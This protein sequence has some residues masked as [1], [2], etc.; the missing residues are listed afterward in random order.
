MSFCSTRLMFVMAVGSVALLA[1]SAAKANLGPVLTAGVFTVNIAPDG[2][3]NVVATGSGDF[4]LTSET[5]SASSSIGALMVPGGDNIQLGSTASTS[6]TT[7][8][9]SPGTGPSNFGSGFDI[10]S[11]GSGNTAGFLFSSPVFTIEVPVGYASDSA[12][13]DSATF[14]SSTLAS[15]GLTPGSYSWTVG[16]STNANTFTIN[17]ASSVPEPGSIGLLATAAIGL[18][19]RRRRRSM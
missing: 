14:S 19:A 17:V 16:T 6:V 1:S 9:F 15:L 3:G 13:S 12:L 4:N 11:S 7:Y 10:P 18:L 2:L 5:N 8:Q